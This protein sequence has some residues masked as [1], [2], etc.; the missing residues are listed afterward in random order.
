[1]VSMTCSS[2]MVDPVASLPHDRGAT[3][4][5]CV[6]AVTL[7]VTSVVSV[8][9]VP[10]A[11]TSSRGD[12]SARRFHAAGVHRAMHETPE[13]SVLDNGGATRRYCEIA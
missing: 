12:A 9:L 11:E 1:M 4:R 13:P 5:R 8:V 6:T 10:A 2:S 7:A 3:V